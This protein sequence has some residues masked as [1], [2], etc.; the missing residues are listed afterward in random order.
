M[1]LEMDLE[2]DLEM[3]LEMDLE[4][5]LENDLEFNFYNVLKMFAFFAFFKVRIFQVVTLTSGSETGD[6]S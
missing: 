3:Y 1:D 2:L 6:G 5:D 4:M